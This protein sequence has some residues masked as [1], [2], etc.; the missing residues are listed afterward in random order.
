[1]R[2]WLFLLIA[3]I[4]QE[5][6]SA[7]IFLLQA[8]QQEYNP[9][10]IHTLFLIA[11]IFDILLGYWLGNIIRKSLF[12]SGRIGNYLNVHFEK[13]GRFVGKNGT[14]LALFF[15]SPIIFPLSALF[16]PLLGISLR[17]TFI[18]SLLG[19]IL[20]WYSV[21]WLVVLGVKTFIP[22]PILAIYVIGIL[23]ALIL[24]ILRYFFK[25]IGESPQ[26]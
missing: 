18:F 23:S 2:L 4:I 14:R 7:N 24:L 1:M 12:T 9:W 25:K 20:C 13:F 6:I 11:T 19:E 8:V 15:Y 22:N 17:E 16:P 3:F 5:P 21:E 26:S 10:L